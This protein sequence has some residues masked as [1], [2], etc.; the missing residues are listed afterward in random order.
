MKKHIDI[1]VLAA[2]ASTRMGKTKQLL[3]WGKGNLLS[4][5]LDAAK[6]SGARSVNL[7]TGA[8]AAHI[9]KAIDLEGINVLNN[10]KWANGMGSSIVCGISYL[11][12]R[13]PECDAALLMLADQPLID[14]AY[15]DRLIKS[16]EGREGGIIATRYNS[17]PGVPAI[18]DKKYFD[19][20][21]GLNKTY[22]ARDIISTYESA[23]FTLDPEGKEIDID[24]FEEYEELVEQ[25]SKK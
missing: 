22:G 13:I 3:P 20:L 24:T 15:L 1:V 21:L 17:G 5:A 16:Y 14:T 23:V 19:D 6:T 7:V 25:H 9:L 18:F 11:K 8:N 4:N 2:G 10:D 12:A